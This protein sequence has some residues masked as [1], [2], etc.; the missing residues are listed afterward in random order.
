MHTVWKSRTQPLGLWICPEKHA[1][2]KIGSVTLELTLRELRALARLSKTVQ[3]ALLES[4][5]ARIT[6]SGR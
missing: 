4:S 6:V 5:Q 2:I 1:H 3:M